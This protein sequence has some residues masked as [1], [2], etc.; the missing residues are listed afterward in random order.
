ML[1]SV[2]VLRR[3]THTF[4]RAKQ[5]KQ[6]RRKTD[7]S[8]ESSEGHRYTG[9]ET[10]LVDLGPSGARPH[11]WPHGPAREALPAVPRRSR[12]K[13]M[14]HYQFNDKYSAREKQWGTTASGRPR[15][16]LAVIKGIKYT[17]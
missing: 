10:A 9:K 16:A 2:G 17:P 11:A 15:G 12:A 7:I 4:M 8:L 6:R 13:K 14:Q 3:A 5:Q 1:K